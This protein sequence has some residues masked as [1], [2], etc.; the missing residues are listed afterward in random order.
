MFIG[1]A[2]LLDTIPSPLRDRM[3]VIQLPGYTEEEKLEIARRYLVARQLTANGLTA[4]QCT[5][6]EAALIAD[7]PGLHPGGRCAQ[8]RAGNRIRPPP[9]RHGGR[10]GL[11]EAVHVGTG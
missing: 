1:T 9:R 2:N 7:H 6:E 3:E 10:R 4:Q 11:T 5:F 8:P